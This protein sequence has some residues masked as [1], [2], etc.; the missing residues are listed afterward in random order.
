MPERGEVVVADM[1]AVEA[2]VAMPANVCCGVF[3]V[4]FVEA[5]AVTRQLAVPD[6][7]KA[8]DSGPVVGL[9]PS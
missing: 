4:V 2:P 8:Q 9:L 6:T 5:D 1:P 3:A 7:M